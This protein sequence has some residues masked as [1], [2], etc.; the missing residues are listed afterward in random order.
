[1]A[2]PLRLRIQKGLTTALEEITPANGYNFDL[3]GKVFR[4]R[5]LFGENDPDTMVSMLEPPEPPETENAPASVHKA[6]SVWMLL[7]QGTVPED[8][9][10]PT[11]GAY[12]L[13]ADVVRRIAIERAKLG[14]NLLEDPF[15]VSANELVGVEID[16]GIVRPAER[17]VKRAFF[18]LPVKFR[19]VEKFGQ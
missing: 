19:I 18:W 17:P 4:G 10:N 8:F 2:D 11:D 12:L 1:M 5:M 7:I 16:Q 15:G 14:G 6:I 9:N 3:S 13:L